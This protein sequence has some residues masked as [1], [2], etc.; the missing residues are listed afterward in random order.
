MGHYACPQP[1]YAEEALPDDH[2]DILAMAARMQQRAT[3]QL[4]AALEARVAALGKA[5]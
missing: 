1:G 4:V 2:P 5:V 3:D